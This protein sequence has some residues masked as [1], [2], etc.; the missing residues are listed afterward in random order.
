MNKK[1]II[2]RPLS[3]P[4]QGDMNLSLVTPCHPLSP[5]CHP[6]HPGDKVVKKLAYLK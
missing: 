4:R 3:V 2:M 5:P 1:T 6:C